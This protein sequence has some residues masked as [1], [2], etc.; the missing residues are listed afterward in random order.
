M[1]F[2]QKIAIQ[3]YMQTITAQLAQSQQILKDTFGY[4]SFRPMQKDIIQNVLEGKDTLVLMPTGGGKSICYQIP[5][6]QLDGVCIVISPLIALMK[7]QVEQLHA[8]GVKAC[9]LN[10]SQTAI[11]QQQLE[12]EVIQ[13]EYDLVYVSPEKLLSEGFQQLLSR[14]NI[15]LFTID[16]AHCISEWGHDFRPEYTR[17]SRIKNTYPNIPVIALTATADKL[18]RKDIQEQ[19]RL[20]DQQVY[21]SSFDRENLSLQV[22]PGQ[23]KFKHIRSFLNKRNDQ[24]GIIY[25]L[26]RKNT[27][28]L[29]AKLQQFG[30]NAASYHAGMSPQERNNVQENF[31]HDNIDIICATIAFGMG[32]NKS[33][34]RWVIHYNLPKNIEGFYQEIGRAGRDGVAADTLLFYS[35]ADVMQLRKFIDKGDRSDLQ[36]SKLERMQQYASAL[37]CRRRILL[38]Y[39]S[40]D[41]GKDCMNCDNCKNRPV[42]EDGTIITQQAL[43]A[44][45]RTQEKVAMGSLIEI[46]RGAANQHIFQHNYHLIKTYGIGKSTSFADWQHYISQM[47][48]LGLIEIAYHESNALKILEEGHKVLQGKKKI[49]LAK[50][51]IIEEKLIPQAKSKEKKLSSSNLLFDKLKTLRTALAKKEGVPPYII[52]SDKSLIDMAHQ[53]PTDKESFLEIHGVGQRK[54]DLFGALFIEQIKEFKQQ[55]SAGKE[56]S[57]IV[58]QKLY[59]ENYSTEDIA[60]K[61]GVKKATII[62]HLMQA[63]TENPSK[64]SRILA[65]N[66]YKTIIDAYQTIGKPDKLKPIFEQLNGSACYEHIRIA[67]M[68]YNERE[69]K[70]S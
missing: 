17:L 44:I 30:Y 59:E 15:S 34:I 20:Q 3:E 37:N 56:A 61:R 51:V 5:G 25:C 58:S 66:E 43:S 54:A 32:I 53:L 50:P 70:R 36:H 62:Q 68:I 18:T 11:E 40:E 69:K 47:L 46:L 4:H 38:N 6:I 35:Y 7:D 45:Y 41:P 52:F 26:S 1:V 24:S 49:A 48:N 33:N 63:Y 55:N 13:G 39:F 9:F 2:L 8:L 42:Y 65:K 67:L 64:L 10:S 27:E 57:Y 23:D 31:I 12:Q 29:A 21:I 28:Q 19:L 22:M 16:E 60:E 14:I